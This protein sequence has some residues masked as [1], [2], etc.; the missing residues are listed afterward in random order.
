M[1]NKIKLSEL[2]NYIKQFKK[3]NINYFD[4]YKHILENNYQNYNFVNPYKC[5]KSFCNTSNILK[6]LVLKKLIKKYNYKIVAVYKNEYQ[7]F[8]TNDYIFKKNTKDNILKY[9]F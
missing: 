4:Y 2:K 9:R 5:K 1:N 7:N 8:N 6:F 3:N